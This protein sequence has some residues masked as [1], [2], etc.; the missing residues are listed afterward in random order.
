[1][2]RPFIAHHKFNLEFVF[3][4]TR[5]INFHIL[6]FWRWH[7]L[8]SLCLE[9][10]YY[11][12]RYIYSEDLFNIHQPDQFD[13]CQGYSSKRHLQWKSTGFHLNRHIVFKPL[14]LGVPYQTCGHLRWI[15]QGRRTNKVPTSSF[16]DFMGQIQFFHYNQWDR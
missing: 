2:T 8:S 11:E 16:L 14:G 7:K 13:L 6:N 4:V 3:K 10:F 1:M 9:N 15:L 5:I 12:C